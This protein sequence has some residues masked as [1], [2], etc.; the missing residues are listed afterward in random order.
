L[1]PAQRF[2]PYVRVVRADAEV[3]GGRGFRVKFRRPARRRQEQAVAA[4]A[5]K[6]RR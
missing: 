1:R 4:A 2:L 3:E 5:A 6:A